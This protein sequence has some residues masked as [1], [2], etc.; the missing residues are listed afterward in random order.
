MFALCFIIPCALSAK[1]VRSNNGLVSEEEEKPTEQVARNVRC[2]FS[3][4]IR[5]ATTVNN[6]P[7][8]WSE[9]LNSKVGS[10]LVGKGFGVEMFEEIAQSLNLHYQVVGYESDKDAIKAL[11]RG[12]LDL[13]IGVYTPEVT[14]GD[15]SLTVYPA[16]FTNVFSVYY[17]RDKAFDVK[18]YGSF[19]NKKGVV[20]R[21][22]NIYS[23]FSSHMPSDAIL[24][25]E[26]TESAF[27]KILSGEADYLIGSPYSIEAELRRYKLHK[28]IISAP[29]ALSQ[30]TLFM[31]LTKGTDCF[32][33]NEL[34]GNAIEK[35][36]ADRGKVN[37][38]I[39]R[40]IDDWG[41]RFRAAPRLKL[42]DPEK[43]K[44]NED[45]D[46]EAEKRSE[47]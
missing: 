20:R 7:F 35:Y 14:V 21:S 1:R 44:N 23:L 26:T 34:L 43:E 2:G 5:V 47:S 12:D 24:S 27:K 29:K 46:H 28:D 19:S 41:E 9:W 11:K 4:A 36:T 32:K 16:M 10:S 8:G 17:R 42:E 6:R 40:L 31:V 3:N 25:V 33:L 15:N 37:E 18:G 13:L 45:E 22:E 39:H 38:K 30:A